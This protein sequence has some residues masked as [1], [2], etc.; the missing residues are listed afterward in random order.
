MGETRIWR[1]GASLCMYVLYL[2]LLALLGWTRWTSM[3]MLATH[4]GRWGVVVWLWCWGGTENAGCQN[5]RLKIGEYIWPWG[6]GGDITEGVVVVAVIGISWMQNDVVVLIGCEV[7]FLCASA[8]AW[9]P[10]P[11]KAGSWRWSSSNLDRVSGSGGS[12][13]DV[14]DVSG[15]L[16]NEI[17][18]TICLEDC[19]LELWVRAKISGLWSMPM[20]NCLPSTKCWNCWTAL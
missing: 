7:S 6:T 14:P 10:T 3:L 4:T 19:C 20:W 18:I 12:T 11:G 8:K 16:G 2:W 13:F 1:G 15:K 5:L 9:K 17:Q